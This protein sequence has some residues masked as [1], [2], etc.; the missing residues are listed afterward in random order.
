M[1]FFDERNRFMTGW[2]MRVGQCGLVNAVGQ[3]GIS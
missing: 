2:S 3:C 1:F